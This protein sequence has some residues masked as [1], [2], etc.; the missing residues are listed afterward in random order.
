[1]NRRLLVIVILLSAT[2]GGSGSV[3][4]A[5]PETQGSSRE[6]HIDWVAASLK[7]MQAVKVG[8]TRD[9]LLKVF[10]TEGGL[11]TRSRR[12]FV[13]RDCPYFKVDVEFRAVA[14]PGLDRDG[15]ATLDEGRQDVIVMIS[16][17]YLQFSI[18][19]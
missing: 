7:R 5:R 14:R 2:V 13:S 9:D 16:K 4:T 10:G 18:M 17:P 8:M 12:T 11:S 15:R 6:D 1:V 3:R 19:D